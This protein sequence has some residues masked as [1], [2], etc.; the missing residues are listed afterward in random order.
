MKSKSSRILDAL[1]KAFKARDAAEVEELAKKVDDEFPDKEDTKD[2]GAS[3]DT[4]IHIHGNGTISGD[5]PDPSLDPDAVVASGAEGA[6][7][8]DDD[9]AAHISQNAAEHADMS[10]RITALETA[11]QALQ[12]SAPATDEESE[13]PK[14]ALDEFPEDLKEEASK[15]KDSAYFGESFQN[16]VAMS[17]ILVPGIRVPTFDS[18]QKPGTTFKK[19]CGLRRQALDL[20]YAQPATRGIVDEILA[21]KEL[22]TK[23]MTC[24][25]VRTLFNAAA[26]TRRAT[27]NATGTR[28]AGKPVVTKTA[29]RSLADI[30]RINAATY[31]TK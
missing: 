14:E 16:T 8:Q 2:E 4:H 29:P 3:G 13:V 7:T 23:A 26:S 18:A 17:E 6:M 30:N 5:A 31:A 22:N 21:G 1:M 19:I 25:A 24:D 10:A 11:L 9:L 28:D 15:A 27:N 12:G 20:A